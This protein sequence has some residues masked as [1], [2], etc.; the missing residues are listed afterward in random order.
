MAEN[1]FF[2]RSLLNAVGTA[3]K[4]LMTPIEQTLLLHVAVE[5]PSGRTW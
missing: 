2:P 3:E 5:G 4:C 1:L